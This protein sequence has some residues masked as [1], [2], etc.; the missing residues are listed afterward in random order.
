MLVQCRSERA[1]KRISSL[2]HSLGCRRMNARKNFVRT[3]PD[4][5]FF[6]DA[7]PA[8]PDV[9]HASD[10]GA[11]ELGVVRSEM[12]A[13]R[14]SRSRVDSRVCPSSTV[15]CAG[16]DLRDRPIAGRPIS[17]PGRH[18]DAPARRSS[19]S[20]YR[21]VASDGIADSAVGSS[22]AP[23]H[24]PKFIFR[25]ADQRAR[26]SA[27]WRSSSRNNGRSSL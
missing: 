8:L 27:R 15:A 21:H 12:K 13:L 3:L 25:A 1:A 11:A 2:G 23:K 4:A 16:L 10:P 20:A 6:D 18:M 9:S 26:N 22:Y 7:T 5:S 14:R 19:A 17:I 24:A